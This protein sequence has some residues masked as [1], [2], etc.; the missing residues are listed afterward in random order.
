[1]EPYINKNKRSSATTRYQ[2]QFGKNNHRQRAHR[3]ESS[4]ADNNKL[5][6]AA[7]RR[8]LRQEQGEIIDAK[9]GYHRLEDVYHEQQ[10]SPSF[11]LGKRGIEVDKLMRRRG[12]LFN[13]AATTVRLSNKEDHIKR[14]TETV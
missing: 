14:K 12:W 8:R 10:K 1:M 13:M 9:F 7:S 6:E 4:G 2:R 3:V 5:D 11:G